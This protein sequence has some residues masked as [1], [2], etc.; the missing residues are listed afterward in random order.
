MLPYRRR[1]IREEERWILVGKGRTNVKGVEGR[2]SENGE[3][4]REMKNGA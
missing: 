2:Y 4:R 3:Y 1:N